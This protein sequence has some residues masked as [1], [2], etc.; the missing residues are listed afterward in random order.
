MH[1]IDTKVVMV[2]SLNTNW[3]M[4]QYAY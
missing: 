1:I 3:F 2:Y 4:Q